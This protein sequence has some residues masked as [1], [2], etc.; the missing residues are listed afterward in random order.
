MLGVLVET[1][2]AEEDRNDALEASSTRSVCPRT[3]CSR[4]RSPNS[5]KRSRRGRWPVSGRRWW[6]SGRRSWPTAA[7]LVFQMA[8]VAVPRELFR[9]I[10]QRIAGLR[11]AVVAR[12]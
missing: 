1:R 3:K 11:L 10:L 9:G 5:W 7:T 6:R 8:E 4:R 12:C 2:L